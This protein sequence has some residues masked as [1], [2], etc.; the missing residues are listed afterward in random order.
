MRSYLVLAPASRAG[1]FKH[2]MKAKNQVGIGL[3]YT[4][5]PG[6]GVAELMPWNRFLGSLKVLKFGLCSLLKPCVTAQR[7]GA[8]PG[9]PAEEEGL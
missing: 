3:S 6:Y 2:S 4:G 7:E 9:E 5:P 8:G 1:I